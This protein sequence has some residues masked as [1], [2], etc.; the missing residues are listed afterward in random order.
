M[1]PWTRL[2][3]S[4]DDSQRADEPTEE[5][6]NRIRMELPAFY[7]EKEVLAGS[8]LLASA[9]EVMVER[10]ARRPMQG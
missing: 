4:P 2:V 5:V 8:R 9:L 10:F 1:K 7:G 3:S 6:A